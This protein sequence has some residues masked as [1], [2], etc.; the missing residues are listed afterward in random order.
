MR[1]NLADSMKVTLVI[2]VGYVYAIKLDCHK[3]RVYWLKYSSWSNIKS[4][5]Y[6]SKKK[7]T[8]ASGPFHS[9]LLG[10]LG[11]SLYFLNTIE[12]RIN[13]MNVSN[14]NI[15]QKIL[16]DNADYK[17]LLAVDKSVQPTC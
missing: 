3:K 11:D 1:F 12:Y 10:V 14:G 5:D 13:V 8:I 9:R 15:S 17:D 4:C 2:H 16:V 7:E 6:G